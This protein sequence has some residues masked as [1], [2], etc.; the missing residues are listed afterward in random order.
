MTEATTSKKTT[1]TA[2][3]VD[4][5]HETLTVRWYVSS[6]GMLM[7]YNEA[8][9]DYETLGGITGLI[10]VNMNPQSCHRAP[11]RRIR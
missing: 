1:S 11:K 8:M 4:P 7:K 9:A 5:H 2:D 3:L 10:E 6:S